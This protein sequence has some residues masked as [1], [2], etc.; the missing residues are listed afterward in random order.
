MQTAADIDSWL[1]W[2]GGGGAWG[3][4]T[5]KVQSSP[6]GIGVG[7]GAEMK[8]VG[9]S[10]KSKV[11]CHISVIHSLPPINKTVGEWLQMNVA[12]RKT[13]ND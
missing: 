8:E 4:R 10:Q 11:V 5:L 7:G 9:K 12:S 13:D 3:S 1:L 2:I 6:V